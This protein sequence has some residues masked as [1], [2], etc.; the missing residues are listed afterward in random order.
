M[1]KG[2]LA[3]NRNVAHRSISGAGL[4]NSSSSSSASPAARRSARLALPWWPLGILAI[5]IGVLYAGVL[6]RLAQD[7]IHDPDYSHG[8]LIP[9]F[10]GYL[11]WRMRRKLARLP[12]RPSWWGFVGI[13]GSLSVL[14]VGRLG[15]EL[16]LTRSSFVFLLAS[17]VLFFLGWRWLRTLVF[18]LACLFLM[19]PIPAIIFDQISLPLQFFASH[20]A[21]SLLTLVG[22]PV[23]REGNIIH[24]PALTLEVAEAC[25]GIRSLISL[26]ALAI[27]YGYFLESSIWRRV[28]LVAAAVPIAVITNAMRIMG[29]G[30]LVE[31]W[32]PE[33]GTGFFHAFS[34]WL[35]FV[36]AFLLLFAF[37]QLLRFRGFRLS[38][39]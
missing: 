26:F 20:V 38:H 17:I 18:P 7:W 35:I 14:V 4:V 34:G 8:F 6:F 9:L 19:I 22:V 10:S 37:H 30:L 39:A 5:F 27:I 2:L 3:L 33:M 11:V 31:Y 25:S 15:A 32:T 13:L 29:T 1:A 28:V 24:L 23:L 12:I 36:M 21:S 16:F